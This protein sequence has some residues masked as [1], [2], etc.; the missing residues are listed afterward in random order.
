MEKLLFSRLNAECF[1]EFSFFRMERHDPDGRNGV[2]AWRELWDR[3]RKCLRRKCAVQ[4]WWRHCGDA[5]LQIRGSRWVLSIECSPLAW[6][7]QLN[8]FLSFVKT[9]V[10]PKNFFKVFL[11]CMKAG[12]SQCVCISVCLSVVYLTMEIV[13]LWPNF[14]K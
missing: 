11:S 12:G 9:F 4:F 5:Q 3:N 2:C 13:N 14:Q 1:M 6:L 7:Q 8:H 10:T